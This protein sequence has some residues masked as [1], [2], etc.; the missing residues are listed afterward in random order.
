MLQMWQGDPP[1]LLSLHITRT[2]FAILL[3]GG[4]FSRFLFSFQP[5][6]IARECQNA[7]GPGK[8]IDPCY[9]CGE[10]G[11][12][13][14]DCPKYGKDQAILTCFKCGRTGHQGNWILFSSLLPFA[15]L[16]VSV[17][18]SHVFTTFFL[19][20]TFFSAKDCTGPELRECYLCKNRGHLAKDCPSTYPARR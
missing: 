16:F 20:L 12:I 1:A 14:K 9:K 11:H 13:A 18:W 5:G 17:L 15:C 3:L 19:F 4:L 2:P 8:H 6:H 7:A 10:T